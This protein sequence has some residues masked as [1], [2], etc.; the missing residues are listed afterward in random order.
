MQRRT[1]DRIEYGRAMGRGPKRRGGAVVAAVALAAIALGAALVP[2]VSATDSDLKH[3]Y[4][5][6]LQ[7]SD[8]YSILAFAVS[9][10]ADGRGEFVLFVDGKDGTA[11]YVS[12]ATVTA[13]RIDA[14]LGALGVVSLDVLPS[15][16]KRKLH[17]HCASEPRMVNIEP[18]LF[19]GSFVFHGEEGYTHAISSSPHEYMAFFLDL[20]CIGA[21]S[22]EV[23]GPQRPGARLRLRAHRGEYHL[24]LQANKNRP[25]ARTRFEV[26]THEERDGIQIS[27][28]RTAWAGAGAFAY[29]PQ[30]RTA[31][32]QPPPP[33]SGRASF[34]RGAAPGNGWTGDLAVDLPGRSDVPLAGAGVDATLVP[35]CWH[36]GEAGFRC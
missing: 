19:R 35:A 24:D 22:G 29:D 36:S 17:S 3:S 4:A 20:L 7:A 26:E 1:L 31:S 30:L 27:R 8:G 33:F 11:T 18:W 2:A 5:F 25:S 23:S 16:K 13:T 10:R 28:V 6:R 14:D 12:P 15:G 9:Q 34:H 21:G 32:L